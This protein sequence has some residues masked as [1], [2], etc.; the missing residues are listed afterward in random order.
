MK[1]LNLL[2]GEQKSEE[3]LNVNPADQVPA[4]MDGDSVLPEEAVILEYVDSKHKR[5]SSWVKNAQTQAKV[6]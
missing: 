2:A 4:P 3:Y 5:T 6:D 1:G